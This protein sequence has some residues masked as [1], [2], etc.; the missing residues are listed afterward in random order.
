MVELNPT[1]Q[2]KKQATKVFN[3]LVKAQ[4]TLNNRNIKVTQARLSHILKL[5]RNTIYTWLK[6]YQLSIINDKITTPLK[7]LYYDKEDT[8]RTHTAGAPDHENCHSISDDIFSNLSSLEIALLTILEREKYFPINTGMKMRNSFIKSLMGVTRVIAQSERVSYHNPDYRYLVEFDKKYNFTKLFERYGNYIPGIR[9]SRTKF[10]KYFI[11]E[12]MPKTI[13][14]YTQMKHKTVQPFKNDLVIPFDAIQKINPRDA[15]ILLADVLGVYEDNLIIQYR[16]DDKQFSRKY[17]QFT[18]IK[19][20][21][22]LNLGYKSYDLSAGLQSIVFNFLD[23]EK[24]PMH[25]ILITDKNR[26][27]KHIAKK[28]NKP[29]KE[30]KQILTAGDNGKGYKTA[31]N[32]CKVLDLYLNESKTIATDFNLYMSTLNPGY[33][34]R[35][36]QMAKNEFKTIWRDGKKEVKKLE[37]K[38]KYSLFFFLWTQIEREARN[39]MVSC[40]ND[41]NDIREVHDAVYSKEEV[42]PYELEAAIQMQ[43]GL[44]LKIEV[45]VRL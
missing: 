32:K 8:I 45:E 9:S 41:K 13:E 7:S 25:K 18:S 29:I 40:F 12:I 28:L 27:R 17:N 6:T 10:S 35:A 36:S 11:N 24:Y 3:K 16:E 26:I 30:V 22:R 23:V 44:T 31:R 20:E 15:F 38:N 42:T 21:T 14:I 2:Q 1:P 19:S 43:T 34:R 5:S 37:T 33:F 4:T 39:A